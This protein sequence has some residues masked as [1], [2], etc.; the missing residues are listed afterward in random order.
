MNA[1][2]FQAAVEAVDL[3]APDARAQILALNSGLMDS[4]TSLLTESKANK[5]KAREALDANEAANQAVIDAEAL[6]LE[7]AND[8][9]GLKKLHATETAKAVAKEKALGEKATNALKDRDKGSIVNEIL[10]KVDERYRS[11]VKT[12][13]NLDTSISYGENGEVQQAIKHGDETYSSVSDFLDGVK[14]SEWKH[15]L[16]ATTFSGADGRQ[17][18]GSGSPT[19]KQSVQSNLASRLKAQG[20][21]Q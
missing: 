10:A 3:S 18:I 21:T 15:Y 17:S 6:R 1:E 11:L 8:M 9:E 13:L 5:T 7:T 16:K 2:E 19:P 12:Q 4:N 14:E 20:L